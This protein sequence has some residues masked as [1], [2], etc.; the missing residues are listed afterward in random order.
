[1]TGPDVSSG[2]HHLIL[3]SL[4]ATM[5]F[6]RPK[7]FQLLGCLCWL[8]LATVAWG[9]NDLPV[10]DLDRPLRLDFSGSWEKDFARSD[11]WEDELEVG[12]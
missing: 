11:K 7:S 1:M 12:S 8:T 5:K 4:F 6:R 2:L 3:M 10:L 9:Q